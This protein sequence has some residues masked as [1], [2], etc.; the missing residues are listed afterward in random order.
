MG[1]FLINGFIRFI[2]IGLCS[3]LAHLILEN[4]TYNR[5]ERLY[6]SPESKIKLIWIESELFTR[7][8]KMIKKNSYVDITKLKRRELSAV[9][10]ETYLVTKVW[11]I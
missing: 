7:N 10:N 9:G 8:I 2:S 6:T 4:P 1:Q 5:K 11:F 3:K